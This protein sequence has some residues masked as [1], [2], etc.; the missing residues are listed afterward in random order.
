[1]KICIRL[2]LNCFSFLCDQVKT[3]RRTT[4]LQFT[5]LEEQ[6]HINP[7]PASDRR[8]ALSEQL[9]MTPRGVQ[10]WF[11]NRYASSLLPITYYLWRS[12]ASSGSLAL[13]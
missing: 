11:Q 2:T 1:M 7:K 5:T 8:Q 6:F 12:S 4:R 13:L 10:I 9:D 3:R